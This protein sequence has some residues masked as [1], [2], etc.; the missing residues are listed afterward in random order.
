MELMQI[1]FNDGGDDYVVCWQDF[2][3]LALKFVVVLTKVLH[4]Y[5]VNRDKN[6][7]AHLLKRDIWVV[8]IVSVEL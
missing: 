3:F 5:Q 8:V 7:V 6:S 4:T 2:I 1:L